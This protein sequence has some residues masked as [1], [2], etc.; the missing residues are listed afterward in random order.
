MIYIDNPVGSGF[1]FADPEGIPSAQSGVADDLYEF[2]V[3]FF[4]LFPEYAGNEF[5]AFGESY[6]GRYVPT[7]CRRIHEMNQVSDFKINLKGFG[8]GNGWM[9]PEDSSLYADFLYQVKMNFMAN[10]A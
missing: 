4:A 6:G 3:Q 9:A 1:S 5:F 8:I 7:I 2:L 10:A